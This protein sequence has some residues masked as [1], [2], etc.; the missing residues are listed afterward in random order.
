MNKVLVAGGAGYIGSHVVYELIDAGFT[1]VVV[2]NLSTG[3]I[4]TVIHLAASKAAGES[5]EDPEKYSKNNIINSIYLI[6]NCLKNNVEK[7]IFSST[8]AVYGYP[9]Y[10]PIDEKH[11]LEPVN[12]Y[13]FTKKIIEEQLLWYSN[14]KRIKIACLRYFNAAGYDSKGRIVKKEKDPANLLPIVMEVAN[15]TRKKIE[16]YGNDYDTPDGTCIRDYIHVKDLAI[17]HIKSIKA[18]DN[19]RRLTLNLATG[20]SYSILDVI[21]EAEKITGLS[22]PYKFV[23]RRSGDPAELYATSVEAKNIL[24]WKPEF[25]DLELILD[26]MWKMYKK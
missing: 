25:S 13:G 7:F 23:D 6:N 19:H 12:Y 15:N 2:D 11:S 24:D 20:M 21:N 16:I 8:A 9:Q 4:D 5:M 14:L 1:V 17:A 18:L 3:H 26:S 10:L 22:I